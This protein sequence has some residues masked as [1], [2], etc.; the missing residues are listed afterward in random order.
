[1]NSVSENQ[2]AIFTIYYIRQC[3]LYN[4]IIIR[5]HAYA[6]RVFR[7][8]TTQ[9]LWRAIAR[10]VVKLRIGRSNAR[11]QLPVEDNVRPIGSLKMMEGEYVQYKVDIPEN[12]TQLRNDKESWNSKGKKTVLVIA[13]RVIRP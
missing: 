3:F 5:D 8:I 10:Y 4:Y 11:S 7:K 2:R 9:T 1:M 6:F 13:C 12:D